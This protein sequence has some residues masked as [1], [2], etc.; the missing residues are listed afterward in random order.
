[1]ETLCF[2]INVVFFLF[3]TIRCSASLHYALLFCGEGQTFFFQVNYRRL[4]LTR[5]AFLSYL[6]ACKKKSNVNTCGLLG[7]Y[8][9]KEQKKIKCRLSTLCQND[10]TNEG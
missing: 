10:Y 7:H 4:C 1:M 6:F 3:K 2:E 8:V 9:I 5:D